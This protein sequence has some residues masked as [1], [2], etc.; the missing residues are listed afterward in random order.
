MAKSEFLSRMSHELRTPL[1]AILGFGQLLE[2]QSTE[3][4]QRNR[5]GYILGAGQHLLNLINEVLDISRIEAGNL[6]LSMEPVRLADAIAE[7]L[8][9]VQPLAADHNINLSASGAPGSDW[10]I[11]GDRQRLK[12]VLLNLLSNGI[13][14]TP[15]GGSVVVS[16]AASSKGVVRLAVKDT[17]RGIAVDKLARLFTP[18][19]RLGAEQSTVEGTGLGTRALPAPRAGDGRLHRRE[20]Q[21]RETAAPSGSSF[22]AAESPLRRSGVPLHE[23]VPQALLRRGDK[24]RSLHRG[25]SFQ[26]HAGRPM[27]ADRAAH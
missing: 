16:Y 5:V 14:Y 18:F 2:R 17:G 19:D 13:K 1:N 20:H 23:R 11:R 24:R 25:Q 27:L 4:G 26:P 15:S 6:Q 8:D 10:F 7:A 3:T 12:Q 9:L 22:P 21:H